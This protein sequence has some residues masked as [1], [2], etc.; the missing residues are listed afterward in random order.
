MFLAAVVTA[1]WILFHNILLKAE[2]K[3]STGMSFLS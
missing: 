1:A 3:Q 2:N